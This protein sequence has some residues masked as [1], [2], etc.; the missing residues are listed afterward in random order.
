[1]VDEY[2]FSPA[3]I[4]NSFFAAKSM[5]EKILLLSI[6]DWQTVRFISQ[7]TE[8]VEIV[9]GG[10][11]SVGATN[12]GA[13]KRHDLLQQRIHKQASKTLLFIRTVLHTVNVQ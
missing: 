10:G 8:F 12:K 7:P 9:W 3:V 11:G 6:A 4:F 13:S 1:M 2:V 5:D